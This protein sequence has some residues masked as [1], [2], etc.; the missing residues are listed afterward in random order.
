MEDRVVGHTPAKLN[1]TSSN[2]DSASINPIGTVGTK[3]D[4]EVKPVPKQSA[5]GPVDENVTY[6]L[7]ATNVCGGSETR[8]ANVHITGMIEPVPE[9]PLASVFFP[10]GYP[11]EVHPQIGLVRSQRSVLA[12]TAEG[13]KMYLIY[14]PEARITLIGH[15]DVRGTPAKNQSLSERRANRVKTCLVKHGVPEDK[16]DIVGLGE[17]ENLSRADVLNC[18]MTTP[19]S[20]S[21]RNATRRR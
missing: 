16:I 13:M 17:K 20:R 21:L 8:T 14:D 3:G 9:V 18:T 4:Q 5:N 10:T 11:D 15:A 19:K 2:A 12:K 6:T 1:W 7:T